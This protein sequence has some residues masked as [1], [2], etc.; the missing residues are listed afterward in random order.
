MTSPRSTPSL[1][2]VLGVCLCCFGFLAVLGGGSTCTWSS[3]HNDDDDDFDDDDT[4]LSAPED[5]ST[6]GGNHGSL[7]PSADAIRRGLADLSGGIRADGGRVG[8]DFV[9]PDLGSGAVRLTDYAVDLDL[10]PGHHP[11][12]RLRDIRGLSVIPLD[13]LGVV[14]ADDFLHFTSLVMDANPDLLGLPPAAGHLRPRSVHFLDE[15]IAV[16]HE[17]V[18]PAHVLSLEQALSGHQVPPPDPRPDGQMIFVF[19]LLGRLLQIE[20]Q[21]TIPRGVLVPIPA[22]L[23]PTR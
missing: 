3:N 9:L 11:I 17:Q 23:A 12:A 22:G 7:Q 21:T 13:Q 10:R 4:N 6:A 5:G 18:H 2:R 8:G 20:N 14:G 16:V 19:D 15:I 1:L